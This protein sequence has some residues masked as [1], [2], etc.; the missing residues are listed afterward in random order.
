MEY[1]SAL[2]RKG[3]EILAHAAKSTYIEGAVLSGVSQS[4]KTNIVFCHLYKLSKV[5]GFIETERVVV[6]GSRGEERKRNSCFIE[7]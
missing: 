4:K 7:F 6:T 1:Y 5:V 3:K 2:K